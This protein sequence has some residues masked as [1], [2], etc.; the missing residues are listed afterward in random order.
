[1]KDKIVWKIRNVL[2]T[3]SM[4]VMLFTLIAALPHSEEKDPE[5]EKEEFWPADMFPHPHLPGSKPRR[6]DEGDLA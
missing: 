4:G 2:I 3:I 1:M 5:P 6:A